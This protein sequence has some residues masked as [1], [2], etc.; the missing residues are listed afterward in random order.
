[1]QTSLENAKKIFNEIITEKNLKNWEFK[2]DKLKN[3][4]LSIYDNR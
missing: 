4:I 3:N 1:M 2:I